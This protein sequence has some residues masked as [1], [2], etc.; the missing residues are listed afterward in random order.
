MTEIFTMNSNKLSLIVLL[1][2]SLVLSCKQTDSAPAEKAVAKTEA[3]IKKEN[4]EKASLT[5]EG[6]TCAIG[7]AKTIEKDLSKANGVVEATVDFDKQEAIISYDKSVQNMQGLSKIVES[8]ADGATYK[9][10]KMV[11]VK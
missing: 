9:V 5:I 7:C 8:S 4:L 3:S 1:V 11:A 6:M 10:S 2:A